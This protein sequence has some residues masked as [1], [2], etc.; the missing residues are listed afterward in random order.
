MKKHSKD[1]LHDSHSH[2]AEHD[3]CRD[4]IGRFA[5]NEECY[6]HDRQHHTH[7]DRCR[8]EIGRFAPNEECDFLHD[9]SSKTAQKEKKISRG[10]FE[11]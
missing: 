3:R 10:C 9:K 5:P 2:H 1:S 7:T 4:E 11:K 8:D 6:E